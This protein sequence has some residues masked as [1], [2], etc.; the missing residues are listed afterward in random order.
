MVYNQ[1]MEQDI[2]RIL[3]TPEKIQKVVRDLGEKLTE[4]YRDKNPLVVGILNGAVPFMTNLT[5]SMSCH[6]EVGYMDVSSYGGGTESSGVVKIIKDLDISAE[7]RHVLI[8]EDIVDSGRTAQA[9]LNLFATRNTASTKICTLLDKPSRRVVDIKPD[10]FGFK[11]PD[12]FVVGYG[13][14]YNQLYRNLPFI[15]VLKE[16][17]YS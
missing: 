8:V 13:L 1:K 7:D 12:E 5:M 16:E 4:D 17:I 15:G 11:T 3:F 6:L 10:Y 2:E 9:L 14:D